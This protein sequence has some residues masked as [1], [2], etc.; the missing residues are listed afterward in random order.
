METALDE[1]LQNFIK[2]KEQLDKGAY[3]SDL[4]KCLVSFGIREI[5]TPLFV[6]KVEQTIHGE[7]SDLDSKSTE[8]LL[9]FLDRT[10]PT[11]NIEMLSTILKHIEDK[12]WIQSGEIRDHFQIIKLLNTYSKVLDGRRI[13][14]QLE[15][16]ICEQC[17]SPEAQ[18]MIPNETLAEI[19]SLYAFEFSRNP[20]G[21]SSSFEA[22]YANFFNY[23]D[24]NHAVL[25]NSMSLTGLAHVSIALVSFTRVT[26]VAQ[27]IAIREGAV[28]QLNNK[29]RP[30]ISAEPI[31]ML[32]G[33]F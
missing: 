30:L 16:V 13:F 7:V 8:N 10:G 33:S 5:A 18:Q 24:Q 3:L 27:W 25:A 4:I 19:V 11:R 31:Q 1:G 29:A 20:L 28:R 21:G 22:F 12:N 2:Y 15:T 32:L 6:A 14:K 9:F 17:F 26:D 23:L